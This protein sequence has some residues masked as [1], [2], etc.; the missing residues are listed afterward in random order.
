MCVQGKVGALQYFADPG[1]AAMFP[2]KNVDKVVATYRVEIDICFLEEIVENLGTFCRPGGPP[3]HSQDLGRV[4]AD[5][6]S[7]IQKEPPD[8]KDVRSDEQGLEWGGPQPNKVELIGANQPRA[9]TVP[10][11]LPDVIEELSVDPDVD[12]LRFDIG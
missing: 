8:F 11:P 5:A 10:I 9:V 1:A 12:Q 3:A 6:I 2:V 7:L 4:I